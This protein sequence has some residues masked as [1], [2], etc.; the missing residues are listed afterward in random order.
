MKNFL[1]CF[2]IVGLVVFAINFLLAAEHKQARVT[3]KVNDVRLLAAHVQPRPA[4]VNDNVHEGTAVRTG[5]ESRAELT[6]IDQTIARLGA[7]TVFNVGGQG[8]TYDLS[9]GAILMYAPNSAGAVKVNTPVATAAVTGFTAMLDAGRYTKLIILEGDADIWLTKHSGEHK[10]MHSGQLISIP[11]G[12]TKLPPVWDVDICK[13]I[14]N[15]RLITGFTK[16]LPS[17][18]LILDVCDRQHQEQ[19]DTKRVDP[20]NFDA[21]DQSGNARPTPPPARPTPD[22]GLFKR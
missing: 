14:S 15:G 11:P 19:P 21:L 18:N 1:R 17:W 10:H 8:R 4:A 22:G 12:A 3:E 6:F 7:N 2:F 9:S 20:T 5:T 16:K 13:L